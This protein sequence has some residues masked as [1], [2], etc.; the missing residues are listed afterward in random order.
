VE[1]FSNIGLKKE[2]SGF[3]DDDS[4]EFPSDKLSGHTVKK[5]GMESTLQIRGHGDDDFDDEF[6][7]PQPKSTSRFLS[8][9]LFCSSNAI[10]LLIE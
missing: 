6:D 4:F 2:G 5:I 10:S 7:G 9:F 3:D 8:F 1:E